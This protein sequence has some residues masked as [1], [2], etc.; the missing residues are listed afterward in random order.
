VNTD[1][2]KRLAVA[3]L[4]YQNETNFIEQTP[5]QMVQA[6]KNSL[7]YWRREDPDSVASDYYAEAEAALAM[8]ELVV[9][10]LGPVDAFGLPIKEIDK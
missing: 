2:A 8:M 3:V 6:H 10:I 4:N 7:E 5:Q 1:L 9:E